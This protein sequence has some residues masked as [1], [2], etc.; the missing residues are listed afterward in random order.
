MAGVHNKNTRS[1]NMLQVKGKN[2]KPEM[3]G[4]HFLHAQGLLYKQHDK[5]QNFPTTGFL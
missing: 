5:K 1:Y 3:P 4:R 2:T